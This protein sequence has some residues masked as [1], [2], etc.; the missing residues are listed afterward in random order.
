MPDTTIHERMKRSAKDFWNDIRP[1]LEPNLNATIHPLELLQ[2]NEL[3]D[4][5]DQVGIDAFS[6]NK[7]GYLQGLASRM[8]YTRYAEQHP[9]FTF[10]YAL[11]NYRRNNWDFNREY[12]RKLYAVN[13][14]DD[15]IMCPHYHVESCK[16]EGNVKWS[17]ITKT[18]DVMRYIEA[19]LEDDKKIHVFEP[20]TKEKR[21]VLSV[22]IP[23]YEKHC[24]ISSI[25]E[26]C[27]A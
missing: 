7:H 12:E 4:A 11:W 10:R 8:Q 13:H 17:Y 25:V 15:A 16:R 23:E 6:V 5:F 2:R 22:S 24:E 14:P 3:V 20:R 1:L 18:A 27:N 21:L 9:V 19:N 26:E